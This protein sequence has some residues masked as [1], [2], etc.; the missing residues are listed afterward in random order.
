[1]ITGILAILIIIGMICSGSEGMMGSVAIGA[2]IVVLLLAIGS[3]SRDQAKA[4]N[5]VVHYWADGGP[6][7]K[8]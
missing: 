6:D 8:H 1:M 5:N 4:Y 3:K 2:V 7:R